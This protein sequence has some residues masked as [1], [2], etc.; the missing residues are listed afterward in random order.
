MKFYFQNPEDKKLLK[1]AISREILRKALNRPVVILCIGT[2][3]STGDA[4][5]PLVGSFLKNA[6]INFFHVYGCL[7]EPVHA[8]NLEET[9]K[10]IYH[11]YKNPFLIAVDASLGS[12]NSV[13]QIVLKDGPLN[14]GAALNKKLP[15]VG[16]LSLTG[17]VNVGGFMEFM[18]LQNTRLS[19][20]MAMARFLSEVL[21]E[22][23][24]QFSPAEHLQFLQ[25][26]G[27][28]R[29]LPEL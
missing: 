20:V 19:T 24:H 15:P 6:R 7:E 14:P 21:I 13:G 27:H 26:N 8:V 28:W 18:V 2:D 29:L 23:S 1:T 17:V 5:G 10:N 11:Q 12:L 3:R 25:G 22:L 16:D 4:F 9:L